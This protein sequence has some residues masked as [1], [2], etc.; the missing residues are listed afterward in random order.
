MTLRSPKPLI[1]LRVLPFIVTALIVSSVAC[2]P[3]AETLLEIFDPASPLTVVEPRGL[4]QSSKDTTFFVAD[5]EGNVAIFDASQMRID[6]FDSSGAFIR[7]LAGGDGGAASLPSFGGMAAGPGRTLYVIL[8]AG[9]LKIDRVSGR[10]EKIVF[11]PELQGNV[12]DIAVSPAGPLYLSVHES[13]NIWSV[14]QFDPASGRATPVH[15]DA[16]RRLSGKTSTVLNHW[17]P[18]CAVDAQGIL[19]IP[20]QVDYR[21]WLYDAEGNSAGVIERS[22]SPEPITERDLFFRVSGLKLPA[23]TLYNLQTT[24]ATFLRSSPCESRRRGID[25]SSRVSATT[26]CGFVLTC[27]MQRTVT[28]DQVG[29]TT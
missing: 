24:F 20:D 25:S 27:T 1:T 5:E 26:S 16:G 15:R 14:V 29:L 4:G 12:A 21:V 2:R 22:A 28:S 11:P 7:A 18:R 10:A 23:S 9:M 3:D 6:E 17:I 19:A 8:A 13:D